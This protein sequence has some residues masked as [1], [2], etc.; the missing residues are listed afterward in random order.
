MLYFTNEASQNVFWCCKKRQQKVS[1]ELKKKKKKALE[2]YKTKQNQKQTELLGA[3]ALMQN[4]IAQAANST[5][6]Q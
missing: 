4:C 3:T 2:K 6:T 1:K 5:R